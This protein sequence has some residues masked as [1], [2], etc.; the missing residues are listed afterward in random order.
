MRIKGR[1]Y[2]HAIITGPVNN[3]IVLDADVKDRGIETWN[4]FKHLF[5]FETLTAQTMNGGLRYYFNY[6]HNDP[7]TAF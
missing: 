2:N 7:D 6:N 4:K 3:I 5:N 1:R